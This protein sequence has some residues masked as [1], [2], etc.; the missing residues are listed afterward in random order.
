MASL[1][2][3]L[4]GL[5]TDVGLTPGRTLLD[6][7]Q[8]L[9]S[10]LGVDGNA[11]VAEIVGASELALYGA[12]GAHGIPGCHGGRSLDI[13]KKGK[14]LLSEQRPPMVCRQGLETNTVPSGI[15][16][17]LLLKQP[18]CANFIEWWDCC[19]SP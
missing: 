3:R 6:D 5:L 4:D 2:A 11:C 10:T 7:V 8:A 19:L 13:N 17:W 14:P 9:A 1:R 12:N 16:S 15:L 18:R